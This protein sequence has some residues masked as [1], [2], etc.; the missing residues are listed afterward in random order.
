MKSSHIRRLLVSVTVLTAISVTGRGLAQNEKPAPPAPAEPP[1]AP[2]SPPS[3]PPV[4][5]APEFSS[6]QWID[7]RE[8]S[9]EQRATF[10]SGFKAVEARVD[11]QIVG[12]NAKRAAMDAATDTRDWD[13][14]MQEMIS[15]RAQL[16]STGEE[17]RKAKPQVWND[18]KE[19]VGLAWVHTQDASAK[20]KLSTTN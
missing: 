11:E 18:Q 1:P 13:L 16:K 9:Y 10:F 8:Y 19:K 5:A 15:A 3:V 6:A 7:I 17:L 2:T 14:A 20:V 12:L 4:P